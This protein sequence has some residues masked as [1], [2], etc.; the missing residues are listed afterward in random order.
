MKC[1][2]PWLLPKLTEQKEF[3]RLALYFLTTPFQEN[4][5]D[6]E[7]FYPAFKIDMSNF[8]EGLAYC[9]VQPLRVTVTIAP[10]RVLPA[11]IKGIIIG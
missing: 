8:N 4:D 9:I 3:E 5:H 7:D 1:I 2:L 10:N 11:A 6:A